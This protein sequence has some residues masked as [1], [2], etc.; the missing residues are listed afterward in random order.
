MATNLLVG[1]VWNFQTASLQKK[2][3]QLTR[4]AHPQAGWLP[5]SDSNLPS[6][7]SFQKL[8]IDVPSGILPLVLQSFAEDCSLKSSTYE[9]KAKKKTT[10]PKQTKVQQSKLFGGNVELSFSADHCFNKYTISHFRVK[11]KVGYFTLVL[12]LSTNRDTKMSGTATMI[13]FLTNFLDGDRHFFCNAH[14]YDGFERQAGRAIFLQPPK[15]K[16]VVFGAYLDERF[17]IHAP[18]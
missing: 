11:Q 13:D 6:F 16:G 15:K 12:H 17:S 4:F 2:V 14:E 18:V 7:D 5:T 8:V 3:N 9:P 1:P 10:T